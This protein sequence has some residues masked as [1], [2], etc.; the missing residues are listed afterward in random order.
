M[1]RASRTDDWEDSASRKRLGQA[2]LSQAIA[3]RPPPLSF[4][5]RQSAA[6]PRHVVAYELE[7]NSTTK[8]SSDAHQAPLLV[9]VLN[10]F[11]WCSPDQHATVVPPPAPPVAA[12]LKLL[13][14][15]PR[16]STATAHDVLSS[17]KFSLAKIPGKASQLE[18]TLPGFKQFLVLRIDFAMPTTRDTSE[19]QLG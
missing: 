19:R 13:V 8:E 12:G 11:G 9:H 18:L 16:D 5:T 6:A 4:A 10:D 3:L 2:M 1:F 7:I 14:S 15:V 17:K